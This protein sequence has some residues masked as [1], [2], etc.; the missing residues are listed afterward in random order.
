LASLGDLVLVHPPEVHAHYS[1]LGYQLLGIALERA[2]GEPFAA[3]LEREVLAPLGMHDSG[4]TLDAQGRGRLARG[5]ICSG[6]DAPLLAAP[7]GSLGCALYSG[8]LHATAE[9]LAR[10][11]IFQ[12]DADGAAGE[13][14]LSAGTRRRMRTPQSIHDP[15]VH[16]CYGLGWAVVRIGDHEA[17]E[18]N[19]SLPGYHAHVSAVPGFRLG[20]VAL[21]NSRH[22]LWRPDACKRLARSVLADL[23]DALAA[24]A[25]P[26]PFDPGAVELAAYAGR[27]S[28]PGGVAHLDVAVEAS[29][30][31]V[32]LAESPDFSELFA[33]AGRHEFCF[34]SD[35][36]RSPA[37]TF[38]CAANGGIGGV[39]FLSHRFLRQAAGR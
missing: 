5:Y 21:S 4:F 13:A 8:G 20:I 36:A 39:T 35:P 9:D 6:P 33:P 18:H 12:L 31:R 28:L 19:G 23:A 14:V 16:E 7:T 30:L 3:Y 27:Y 34:A 32:T 11:L 29:G 17:I 25:A 24:A 1:N 15:G 22:P 38:T 37:L 2:A 10:F 26:G